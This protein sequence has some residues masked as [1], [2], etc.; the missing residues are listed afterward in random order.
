MK[1][2]LIAIALLAALPVAAQVS[3]PMS[4]EF[5]L[6]LL[7]APFTKASADEA[8]N[9]YAKSF[10]TLVMTT[11][12]VEIRPR[13]EFDKEREVRFL[14][15]PG[16]CALRGAGYIL[17]ERVYR[18]DYRVTLKTRSADEA[19]VRATRLDGPEASVKLEEDVVPPGTGKLSR[20]ATVRIV[21]RQAPRTLAQAAELFPALKRLATSDAPLEVVEGLK[22]KE[23][24]YKLP[25]W[26]V[27]GV[28]F[29]A[30]LSV[31]HA[32]SDGRLLFVESDFSYDVP[33]DPAKAREV[34]EKAQALFAAMQADA[35]WAGAR[36]QT[37]TDFTY[38]A[39]GGK[40][41]KP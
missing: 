33:Q 10:A 18:Q 8:A 5:K 6:P 19:W 13:A 3:E 39:A 30:G 41:C 2:T 36:T 21:P 7:E 20:S 31:W 24:V 9:A 26:R 17:R 11:Q 12:G 37:K 40:F 14:D 4:R 35:A 38:G 22:V 28:K 32:A 16:T 34:A 1:R 25:D 27:A 15:T 23:T 29:E